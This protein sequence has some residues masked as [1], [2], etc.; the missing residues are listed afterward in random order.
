MRR[1]LINW[2]AV[3]SRCCSVG[4]GWLAAARESTGRHDGG[5]GPYKCVLVREVVCCARESIF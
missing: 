4:V 3:L 2:L 1:R 5:F